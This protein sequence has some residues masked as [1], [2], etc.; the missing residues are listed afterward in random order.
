M[1]ELLAEA[2]LCERRKLI[3]PQRAWPAMPP[4]GDPRHGRA[5]LPGAD[6]LQ[7]KPLLLP[8]LPDKRPLARRILASLTSTATSFP[9]RPARVPSLAPLSP[10]LAWPCVY[11]ARSQKLNLVIQPRPWQA[12]A[13]DPGTGFGLER[14]SARARL[15][16][17]GGDHIPQGTLQVFL[18]LR[19]RSRSAGSRKPRFYSYSFPNSGFPSAYNP[20]LMRAEGRIAAD[21]LEA[22]R[23]R[24]H[25]VEAYPDWW[26]GSCLYGVITRHPHTGVLQGGADPRGEAYAVG[27]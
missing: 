12:S 25:K 10:A 7:P 22:L 19:V 20:G 23:Q 9:V 4:A 21:V 17:Y 8:G 15:G 2:Y 13:P 3:D 27:Y 14:R 11:V 5:T 6:S 1:Q 16:G 26:E 24:G 18:N